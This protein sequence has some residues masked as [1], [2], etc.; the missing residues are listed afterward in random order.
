MAEKVKIEAE[1]G[2]RVGAI[3]WHK[4]PTLRTRQEH[5]TGLT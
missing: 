5:S 2:W 4:V 3:A 1:E